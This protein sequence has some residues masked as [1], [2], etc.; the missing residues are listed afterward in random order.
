VS[1]G[2]ALKLD[3]F[4]RSENKLD[5]VEQG[6]EHSPPVWT[7]W[8]ERPEVEVSVSV[9]AAPVLIELCSQGLRLHWKQAS[10]AFY[11]TLGWRQTLCLPH[12]EL[13]DPWVWHTAKPPVRCTAEQVDPW[14]QEWHVID[15]VDLNV[16]VARWSLPPLG[17][18]PTRLSPSE[19]TAPE[20]L[21][22]SHEE[23][24][25]LMRRRYSRRLA[26]TTRW[27]FDRLRA[28]VA[29]EGAACDAAKIALAIALERLLLALILRLSR[30]SSNVAGT[31]QIKLPRSISVSIPAS[32]FA[33]E[34]LSSV[35]TV[36]AWAANWAACQVLGRIVTAP[37][38]EPRIDVAVLDA[39]HVERE[40]GVPSASGSFESEQRLVVSRAASAVKVGLTLESLTTA[41]AALEVRGI[42]PDDVRRILAAAWRRWRNDGVKLA[43]L[44]P[45]ERLLEVGLLPPVLVQAANAAVP[46]HP[47]P[48][49][50]LEL[51]ETFASERSSTRTVPQLT[52]APLYSARLEPIALPGAE[53]GA[54][55][56]WP[57]CD[58]PRVTKGEPAAKIIG[59]R[60]AG[61]AALPSAEE[62]DGPRTPSVPPE[63]FGSILLSLVLRLPQPMRGVAWGAA[64]MFIVSFC[65]VFRATLPLLLDGV[66]TMS[67]LAAGASWC[68]VLAAGGLLWWF[69]RAGEGRLTSNLPTVVAPPLS[70]LPAVVIPRGADS[71]LD[72]PIA[73]AQRLAKGAGIASKPME[74][75][76]VYVSEAISRRCHLASRHG[77]ELLVVRSPWGIEVELLDLK[78]LEGLPRMSRHER[79]RRGAGVDLTWTS[80]FLDVCDVLFEVLEANP[81]G[82]PDLS[83]RAIPLVREL[84]ALTSLLAF[85]QPS[86]DVTALVNRAV[87]SLGELIGL[88]GGKASGA[89]CPP[90]ER[91]WQVELLT[92]ARPEQGRPGLPILWPDQRR[93]ARSYFVLGVPE[94]PEDVQAWVMI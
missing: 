94:S 1:F 29:R 62:P 71:L 32:A 76:L 57:A 89:E 14:L 75:A 4:E 2:A 30:E 82:S 9:S 78:L 68:C 50:D 24:E 58:D 69:G 40:P 7:I 59:M 92:Q 11:Q 51:H 26:S 16:D 73:R 81:E 39:E 38:E 46:E 67:S 49:S 36:V 18:C 34:H 28:A 33:A 23:L 87:K 72:G 56:S 41:A 61:L 48:F 93:E 6:S 90:P 66:P 55:R 21:A 86:G 63:S 65:G 54:V 22:I 20:K 52:F 70:G 84:A 47:A 44:D 8:R 80:R 17:V 12:P 10:E 31:T 74:S 42:H 85:D 13:A 37:G 43:P 88:L 5:Q 15:T 91:L 79:V 45:L 3:R 83:A 35:Q 27:S 77:P 53:C 25:R 64:G 60:S 19:W